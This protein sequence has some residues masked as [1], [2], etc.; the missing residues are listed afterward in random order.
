MCSFYRLHKSAEPLFYCDDPCDSVTVDSPL[1]A[2]E[3]REG[4]EIREEVWYA[5]VSCCT[6][7]CILLLYTAV[8]YFCCISYTALQAVDSIRRAPVQR[9]H[10]DVVTRIERADAFGSEE[11]Q[12]EILKQS[13]LQLS[14]CMKLHLQRVIDRQW[15]AWKR[16]G[17]V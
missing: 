2:V 5:C 7:L 3:V 17:Y 1:E 9:A 15:E 4:M 8:V 14:Y 11:G 12:E 16:D 10:A 13:G 6:R